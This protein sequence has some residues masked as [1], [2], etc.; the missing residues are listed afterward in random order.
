KLYG[1]AGIKRE[2]AGMAMNLAIL[3]E[4]SSKYDSAIINYRKA[5]SVFGELQDSSSMAST[6]EN[7]A[8]ALYLKGSYDSALVYLNR[9][10]SILSL[11]TPLDAERWV[12]VFYNSGII[13]GA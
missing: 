7:I 12:T 5:A 11:N 8:I 1:Q 3:L 13:Y 6:L 2:A 10:D 9:T 4:K